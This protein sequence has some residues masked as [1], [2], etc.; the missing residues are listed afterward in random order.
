MP[1]AAPRMFVKAAKLTLIACGGATAIGLA[2]SP[3]PSDVDW[4]VYGG[5]AAG[6]RYSELDQ[7]APSNVARLRQAWQ[8]PT[9]PGGLQTSPIVIGRTLYGYAPDQSVIALDAATGRVKWRFSSGIASFQPLRGLTYWSQGGERRLFVTSSYYLY[10]L[11]PDSGKAVAAFGRNGRIDLRENLGRD[12]KT[13]AVFLTTPA[14]V[15]KDVLITGFRTAEGA[16][17][18]PGQIRAFDVRTGKLR[19]R[20]NTIPADGEPGSG[21]WPKGAWRSAGG[22]NNWAGMALD[23]QRGIVYVPTGSAVSDFYGADRHGDNL[24][25]NSLVALDA[26][27][28]RRL[29]HFQGVH[30]DLWDRDF[31]SPPSLLTVVHNGRR[32]DA[33]AQA[34]KQGLL[35]VFDRATG[36]PLFPI[37]ERP[38]PQSDVP[39]ER[40]SPTQPFPIKPAPLARQV[41]TEQMLTNRTSEARA[42][43]LARFRGL[44]NEGPYTPLGTGRK[45]VIMPGFD[46]GAE[47][48]GA[49][50]DPK[51]GILYVNAND[52]PWLGSL[53]EQ[54]AAGSAG[55]GEQAYLA[56]CAG[57][58]GL[59]RKGTPPDFPPVAGIAQRLSRQ[60][61]DAVI[62]GGRG[63]MPGFP[64][65]APT[66]R[67]ALIDFLF[68]EPAAE[69]G[70]IPAN[71]PREMLAEMMTLA[72]SGETRYRFTGYEKFRD[73]DGYPA[74][75][76]PWGT[77]NAID[78]NTGEYLWKIPLGEY[79]EL[80]AKGMA[81]TGSENYG[82]PLLTASSL[83]FIGA[84]IYDRKFRAFDA[85]NG[86]LLWETTLPY[87]GVAAPITYTVD[88]RQY[89][90]IA[91][92][93]SRD[94]K[95]TQ[96]SAYVAFALPRPAS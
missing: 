12:P 14:I 64:Q 55:P 87:A 37:V 93:G 23:E 72:G 38:V 57:C 18:A 28:G 16:P 89:V 50:V 45:T 77:L 29:W 52:V 54:K 86:E 26:G 44:R 67:G 31:P 76:P 13:L 70:T 21:S 75:A 95:A 8:F 20:F 19:W 6:Q 41:L 7:I 78:L 83:L 35:F 24:Y 39:G 49:A 17:A 1:I 5:N 27:T 66:E 3:P 46:G 10:A 2:A 56:H 79:P 40:S 81:T 58:H 59:N 68:S 47:W 69:G 85:R 62:V 80:A 74:V 51:R 91:A 4:P 84:T 53:A 61:V 92:S 9:G 22:A 25:A 48:G 15:Y 32:I 88:G 42:A 33:V 36:K 73:P 60:Q 82:G 90:V 34:S 30:H 63:R 43:V 11:D 71:M 65:L 96:G 94:P